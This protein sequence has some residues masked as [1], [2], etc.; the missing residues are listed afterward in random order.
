[1][2]TGDN[3]DGQCNVSD[4]RDIVAVA[5]GNFFT[6]GLRSDGTVVAAGDNKYGGCDVSDWK[7][8]HS[9]DRLEQERVEER[10][11]LK[12]KEA[13][14][15]ARQEAERVRREEARRRWLAEAEEARRRRE[16][17][18]AEAAARKKAELETER[19]A[20][21]TELANL[22]GLFTGKRRKELEARLADIER[23]LRDL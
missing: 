5:A 7:L 10:A 18:Q 14:E 1:M 13:Q 12:Q 11:H 23:A 19:S 15:A 16:Q 21:Q 20:L 2:A 4:W 17:E 8:F 3:E 6:V 22:K 9:M